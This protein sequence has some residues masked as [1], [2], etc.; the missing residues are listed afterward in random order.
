MCPSPLLQLRVGVGNGKEF[1][2]DIIYAG[3]RRRRRAGAFYMASNAD[4][5]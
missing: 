4:G 3:E 5:R 2:G 1:G